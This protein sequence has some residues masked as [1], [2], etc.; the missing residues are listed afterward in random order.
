M[1]TPR[2]TRLVRV[3]DLAAF[4]RTLTDL[5]AGL[6]PADARET[7]VLVPTRAAAEQL[8]RT[9]ENRLLTRETPARI[10]PLLGTRTDLSDELAAR[11][12]VSPRLLNAFEREVMLAA[13]ARDLVDEGVRPPFQIRPGLIAEMLALYDVIRRLGR[14]VADFDR[15]F[16]EELEK[17]RDFDR[18]AEKLLQQTVFLSALYSRYE[19]RVA[20]AGALD[21]HMLR[22]RLADE[23]STRALKRIVVTV[24]DRIADPD[25]LWPADYELLTKLPGLETID[26]VSTEAVLA[27]GV[28][29]RLQSVLPQIEDRHAEH[30]ASPPPLLISPEP[31]TPA[32][33]APVAF[34][35][36]DREEELVGIARRLKADRDTDRSSPLHRT[37][38]VVQRPLPYL[39]LARDVFAGAGVSFETLDTLPLAAEPYAAAL[40]L[41][42]DV[43]SAEYSRGSLLA[44]L[45][46]PHFRIGPDEGLTPR[47][48]AAFDFALADTR[49]LGGLDRLEDLARRWSGITAPASRDERRCQTAAPAATAIASSVRALAPLA[50]VR[51]MVAQIETLLQWL[52]HFDR[53]PAGSDATRL[54]S[55]EPLGSYGGQADVRSP[56]G[57]ASEGRLAHRSSGVVR[58]SEGGRRLRVRAAVIGALASLADAYR[59]HDPGAQGDA[60]LLSAAMR[61]WLGGQTFAVSTGETG[62][63]IVDAQAARFGEF[64]DV[65]L[66]GLI[67]GE[68]PERFRRNVLYPSSLLAQL[69]PLPAI[70]DP[71]RRERDALNAARAAF[72]DLLR[73]ATRRVRLSSFVLENDAVV[74]PS[75]LLDEVGGAG[76][77]RERAEPPLIR[78]FHAEAIALEPRLPHV[79]SAPA[80]RWAAAR[81]DRDAVDPSHFRGEAGSWTLPRVSVSRLE[82]YLDCPFRFFASEVLRLEEQPEDEDTRTPLERGRFLHELFERF[83]TE[84]QARGH[85]RIDPGLLSEARELFGSICEDALKELSPAEATL[86]RTRLLGS[87]VSPGIAHRVFAM[88]AE[89]ATEI[90]ERLLEYPLQGD[91]ELRALDGSQ[92][93]VTLSAKTDRIDLLADGTLR[94]IDYKSKKTPELKVAL[95]LPIYSLC[96]RTRLKG[97]ANRQWTLAEA[98]YL[99][100]EGNKAIVPLK[101]KGRNLDEL[102]ADAQ[103]RLL[104]TLDRIAAGHFPPQPL[105]RS[106]CGSCP[107]VAVCRLEYVE[108]PEPRT[109]TELAATKL[110]ADDGTRAEAERVAPKLTDEG[111]AAPKLVD[112]DARAKAGAKAE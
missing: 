57:P 2:R 82:R 10:W 6:A 84:W 108:E 79:L 31:A 71:G 109:A 23:S 25:G 75:I 13:I 14:T 51:P 27:A 86:E 85:R 44:L 33:P 12:A 53:P 83:F 28:L 24:A 30:V 49:Y 112:E 76:L 58:T 88:E 102:I 103:D 34:S 62:V 18:G 111:L 46:S 93:T 72:K 106:L 16:R 73:L 59:R 35:H 52:R 19:M 9:L 64:D 105:R 32:A 42:L 70:A 91:F 21:E 40:D 65:Q 1:I 37:A 50:S 7:F 20:D 99:S 98:V 77:P 66:V 107:Y 95:Q 100:F 41:A 39:Y 56:E 61:R 43:V 54:R 8:R 97:H 60:G 17:D 80:S 47:A 89:R 5:A 104:I 29:E 101:A 38:V 68:W 92:R 63:Q 67:D 94:V 11:L 45:R 69:E 81:L 74:E 87:A 36:R 26:I 90:V 4:Q 96:A 78:V 15:N 48:I 22:A 55:S 110:A 3:P